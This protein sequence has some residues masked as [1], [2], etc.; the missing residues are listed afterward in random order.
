MKT[1]LGFCGEFISPTPELQTVTEFFQTY[2]ICL[3][4]NFNTCIL[5]A[6]SFVYRIFTF[7]YISGNVG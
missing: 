4:F 2:L 5:V 1:N 7:H 3:T 6:S